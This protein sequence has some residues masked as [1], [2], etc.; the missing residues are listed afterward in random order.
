MIDWDRVSELRDEVGADDFDEVVDL[1]LGEVEGELAELPDPN[2]AAALENKL[3]FLKGSALNLGF[4]A[5][6]DLCQA[7]ETNAKTGEVSGI[8]LPE[9][10]ACYQK[11]KSEFLASLQQFAAA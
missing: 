5:F 9:I 10:N 3:H 8:N 4:S 7:G 2:D 6:A 11:S 1:F